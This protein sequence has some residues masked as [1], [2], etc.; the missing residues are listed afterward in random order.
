MLSISLIYPGL[1]A[2]TSYYANFFKSQ[3]LLVI[4]IGFEGFFCYL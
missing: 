1:E 2:F 3:G 4:L